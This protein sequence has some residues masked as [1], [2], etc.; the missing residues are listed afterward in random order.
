[1]KA[2][3]YTDLQMIQRV[4]DVEEV[5]KLCAKRCYYLANDWRER[6]L[7]LVC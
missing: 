6:E 1:M 4:W 3:K 7:E 2:P 5:K